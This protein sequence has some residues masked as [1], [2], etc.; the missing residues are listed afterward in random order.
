MAAS[1]ALENTGRTPAEG[2]GVL[3]AA[4]LEPGLGL[5]KEGVAVGLELLCGRDAPD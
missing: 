4:A 2:K 1:R 5:V 3:S